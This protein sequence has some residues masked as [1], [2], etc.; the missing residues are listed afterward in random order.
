M[1]E[2]SNWF[3][4]VV[5]HPQVIAEPKSVDDIVAILKDP[6]K[7]PSPVRGVGSNH[8]TSACGV[9]ER[10]T[11]I[12]MT[13]M[14]RILNIGT[15]SVTVQAGA[16]YIDVA[17]ELQK[18][19][20]QFYV[21]T[22]IGSLSIGSAACAGTKDAS[23]PG[24]FGQV[25]SYVSSIKMVLP[26][27]ELMEVTDSQPELM[28]LVR[29]SYGLFGVVYEAT[30]RIR[31]MQPLAVHHETFKLKDFVARLPK[32]KARGES[33]MFYIFPFEDLITVEFR[34]Y[35]P[36]AKGEPNRHV[37]PL[38]NYLWAN[39]G[40]RACAQTERDIAVPEIKYKIIDSLNGLLRF[41][42]ENVVKSDN[43]VAADQIIRY[44]PVSDDS[45]Y[46]FTLWAFPEE[47]YGKVLSETFDFARKYFD[48]TGYRSNMLYVGYRIAKDQNSLFSYSYDFDV[49]TIDPVST[50]NPGWTTFLDA[51]NQFC[52][53]R[54]GIPLFN[55]TPQLT[56]AQLQ[57]ALGGR[58]QQ[59]AAERKKYDPNNR[60]LN[61]YFR[62]MLGDAEAATK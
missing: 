49:M 4:D 7:Y 61:D 43:T 27:G 2:I 53:D 10:G 26:S 9:A 14:N 32:L 24:E 18:R 33:M 13:G 36:G 35:N 15:D 29:S 42:L 20:L 39:S 60:L 21:N 5:S 23:M 48:T 41:N 40:P 58:L 3:G 52:S 50:A 30:F 34:R 51:Y 38:R 22:E 59:F 37:W 17:Q 55:Q 19:N 25:G 57:K 12:K 54:G 45:R 56:R 46:T 47:D 62:D 6:V 1:A 44:P 31:A 8:S 11:V 28:R 16:I